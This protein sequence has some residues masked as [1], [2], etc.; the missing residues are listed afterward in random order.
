MLREVKIWSLFKH[1]YLTTG[2]KILWKRGEIAP[3]EG[4]ISPLFHNIFNIFQTSGV[5]LQTFVKCGYSI[6][7]FLLQI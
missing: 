2:N 5:K 6:Y 1:E 7:F 4:A 3:K